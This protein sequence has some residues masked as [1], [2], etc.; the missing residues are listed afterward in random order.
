MPSSSVRTFSYPDQYAAAIRGAEVELTVTRRGGFTAKIT[1]IDFHRLW[2]QRFEES[3]PRIFYASLAPGRVFFTFLTEPCPEV[4]T[5]GAP[6]PSD[7]IV[8]HGIADEFYQCSSGTVR[9]GAVSLPVAD[10]AAL[11]LAITGSHCAPRREP[12]VLIPPPA[13]L[14][15]FHRLHAAAGRLAE[16]APEMIEHPEAARGLEQALVGALVGCFENRDAR[17]EKSARRHHDAIMRRFSRVVEEGLDRALYLPELCAALGVSDRTLRT[18]C[19][20]HLGMGPKRYLLL[21]RLHLAHRALRE[22][23]WGATTVTEV[24]T[25]FG[26]WELGRFAGAYRALFG[27]APSATLRRP[28][29]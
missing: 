14:A 25:R 27:E 19:H 8:C 4:L 3:A 10:M 18:C 1:R 21:R 12:K 26:F 9:R 13:A 29:S 5:Y 24:A 16:E 6:M 20:E 17:D 2:M 28:P 23:V 15:R 11:E 7:G 22:A